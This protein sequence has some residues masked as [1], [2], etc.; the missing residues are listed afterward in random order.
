MAA[1]ARGRTAPQHSPNRST[2]PEWH[3][4][5]LHPSLRLQI[6]LP[7]PLQLRLSSS[8]GSE[9]LSGAFIHRPSG[10]LVRHACVLGWLGVGVRSRLPSKVHVPCADVSSPL[11]SFFLPFSSS[12]WLVVVRVCMRAD[13]IMLLWECEFVFTEEGEVAIRPSTSA[14]HHIGGLPPA[15]AAC[16][17][18]DCNECTLSSISM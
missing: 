17:A 14:F 16:S 4:H 1:H 13:H 11:L 9:H 8:P 7:T 6:C 5:R 10:E 15:A 2:S 3:P 18:D 12:W